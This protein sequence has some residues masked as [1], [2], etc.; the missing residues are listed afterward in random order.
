[1]I[2]ITIILTHIKRNLPVFVFKLDRDA[3][4]SASCKIPFLCFLLVNGKT[5]VNFSGNKSWV[6]KLH[7]IVSRMPQNFDRS[8]A[9]SRSFFLTFRNW[10]RW[11]HFLHCRRIFLSITIS[12]LSDW[13][14]FRRGSLTL[15]RL[16]LLFCLKTIFTAYLKI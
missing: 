16:F 9:C 10:H 14:V 15:V 5:K 6:T 13:K 11:N 3:R 12:V 8:Y 1:M 7:G 4:S 2:K